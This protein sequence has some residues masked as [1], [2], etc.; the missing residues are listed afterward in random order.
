MRISNSKKVSVLV[1]AALCVAQTVAY[2]GQGFEVTPSSGHPLDNLARSNFT[3]FDQKVTNSS[4]TSRTW[5]TNFQRP[6]GS[7]LNGT[8]GT[9]Q[10]FPNVM[11]VN[12][13]SHRLCKY[14]SLGAWTGCTAW[15]TQGITA[16]LSLGAQ[17]SVHLQT[18]L[19]NGGTLFRAFFWYN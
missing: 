6:S 17:E 3:I 13:G 8:A 11:A 15:T 2:A 1:A 10:A 18:T 9:I 7:V 14:S 5:I 4:A 12:T 16:T 19:A